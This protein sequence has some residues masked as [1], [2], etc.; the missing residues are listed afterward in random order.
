MESIFSRFS[1]TG[2]AFT[3]SKSVSNDISSSSCL[4]IPDTSDDCMRVFSAWVYVIFGSFSRETARLACPLDEVLCS[5]LFKNGRLCVS[6][7]LQKCNHGLLPVCC[8]FVYLAV[9]K[10]DGKVFKKLSKIALLD[11]AGDI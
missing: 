8:L 1:S 11:G 10:W 6:S 4:I 3:K 2:G 9:C 7:K 5:Q